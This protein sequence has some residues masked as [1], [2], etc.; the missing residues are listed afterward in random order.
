MFPCWGR[1]YPLR[2]GPL[3]GFVL[4]SLPDFHLLLPGPGIELPHLLLFVL[5]QGVA[6]VHPFCLF[7]GLV[8][9]IPNTCTCGDV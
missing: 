6:G 4:S 9:L 7:T 2:I 5:G 1:V 3:H 8:I